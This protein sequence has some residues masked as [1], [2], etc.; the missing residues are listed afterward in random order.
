MSQPNTLAG[1]ILVLKDLVTYQDGAVVSRTI[2][3]RKIGT[4]TVFS[5]AAGEGLSEHTA[6][7]D[8]VVQILDG[9][10]EITIA[11]TVYQVVAGELLIMPAHQPHALRAVQPFKM[12]LTMIRA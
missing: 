8:A 11:G 10:A 2:V 5:F 3:D 12:L 9:T 4:L 6:P 7:F 1:Q